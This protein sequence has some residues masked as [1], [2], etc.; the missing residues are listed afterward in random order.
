[1]ND[2]SPPPRSPL[3][4][5]A[6]SW[7]GFDAGRN[8]YSMLI[9][10]AVFTPY[11]ATVLAPSPVKGQ[12]LV[13]SIGLWS[14][15]I[16]A[17]L[18]TVL[19]GAIDR[20]G[21]RKPALVVFAVALAATTTSF[22]WAA[23]R[24]GLSLGAVAGLLM[25]ATVLYWLCE[26]IHNAMLLGAAKPDELG[27]A[28]GLGA[29]LGFLVASILLMG[30]LWAFVLPAQ[31]SAPW[32]P[33][34]PLLGLDPSAHEPQR[35]AGPI[36]GA[37]LVL[38]LLPLLAFSRDG[39]RHADHPIQAIA[40]SFREVGDLLG[41][42]IA[43]ADIRTFLI[44]RM[45][46]NSGHLGNVMFMSVYAAGAFGWG[47]AQLLIEALM[48]S[49]A[50]A[51]GGAL[52][53]WLDTRLGAKRALLLCLAANAIAFAG[54]LGVSHDR[55]F[56]FLSYDPALNGRPWS[57]PLYSTWPE[58]IFAGCDIINTV[59]LVAA[60]ALSRTLMA[61]LSPPEHASSLFGLYSLSAA[62]TA[63]VAPVAVG[64]ATMAFASQQAGLLPLLFLIVAGWVTLLNVRPSRETQAR[65]P[66]S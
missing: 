28:S 6:V 39:E 5:S 25:V 26:V 23:P 55:M 17:I 31:I 47:T 61:K 27:R 11:V 15:V 20:M 63:W 65:P 1:M 35:A 48:T 53:S 52:S 58:W 36:V 42:F 12:E 13:A 44:A 38:T 22:W 64:T 14:G 4:L 8:C 21:L 29:T 60:I 10:S 40:R 57:G 7:A 37:C 3:T 50:A 30:F 32:I 54:M 59:F 41:H 51:G 18:A 2:T 62:A 49:V 56:F 24:G 45:L 16:G 9:V 34:R 46:F 43:R 19:G 66:A 33:A